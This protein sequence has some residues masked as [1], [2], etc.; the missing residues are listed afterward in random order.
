MRWIF[1]GL[2][3]LL[4]AVFSGCVQVPAKIAQ[5][6]DYTPDPEAVAKRRRGEIT[7]D[8]TSLR[9]AVRGSSQRYSATGIRRSLPPVFTRGGWCGRSEGFPKGCNDEET[10]DGVRTVVFP[11]GTQGRLVVLQPPAQI[12]PKKRGQ[13]EIQTSSVAD[14]PKL[15]LSTDKVLE[16]VPALEWF[17]SRE[18]GGLLEITLSI[19]NNSESISLC[20]PVFHSLS[21]ESCDGKNDTCRHYINLS[22][23]NIHLQSNLEYQVSIKVMD[24]T[25][26]EL[27]DDIIVS[28][29]IRYMPP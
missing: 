25:E 13:H 12:D 9:V 22:T 17:L 8:P 6:Y 16:G 14:T 3:S 1:Y 5:P 2:L 18:W 19:P 27:A 11:K 24:S 15:K 4:P 20:Y 21:P 10:I 28:D 26:D 29:T 23:R 7:A